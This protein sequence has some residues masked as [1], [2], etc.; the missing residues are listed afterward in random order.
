MP[1]RSSI[2]Q[3]PAPT[4]KV[5]IITPTVAMLPIAHL[6]SA[7]IS[8]FTCMAPANSSSPSMP[9]I[10]VSVKSIRPSSPAAVVLRCKAGTIRSTAIVPIEASSAMTTSPMVCGNFSQR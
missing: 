8:R 5:D 4:M 6:R 10:K 3:L 1:S 9:C 2:S 7:R